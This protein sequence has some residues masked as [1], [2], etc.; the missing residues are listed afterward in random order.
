M[1]QL[2]DVQLAESFFASADYSALLAKMSTELRVTIRNALASLRSEFE[3]SSE[4]LISEVAR[5][6]KATIRAVARSE[7]ESASSSS[8]EIVVG[9]ILDD[10]RPSVR[11]TVRTMISTRFEIFNADDSS[12]VEK[13]TGRVIQQI[14][15]YTREQVQYFIEQSKIPAQTAKPVVLNKSPTV[16]SGSLQSIF[17]ISGANNVKVETPGYRYAYLTGKEAG[18]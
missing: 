9:S 15:E 4:T 6:I 18:L 14:T 12:F 16:G 17:G 8:V 13:I 11:Q 7:A 2:Q 3:R 5:E 10:I 1:G